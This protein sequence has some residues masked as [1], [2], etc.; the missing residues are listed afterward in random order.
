MIN[1]D[2]QDEREA[3]A[4]DEVATEHRPT[5][6]FALGIGLGGS[7]RHPRPN[8]L[9]ALENHPFALRQ[10]GLHNVKYALL[11]AKHH[12]PDGDRVVVVDHENEASG[13][14]LLNGGLRD[15][16]P[17]LL[18]ADLHHH[19]HVLTRQQNIIGIRKLAA[20]RLG[21]GGWG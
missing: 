12:P 21:A 5:P 11:V 18:F 9:H 16:Q 1:N 8:L 6:G 19:F 17:L 3:R 14:V 4:I 13:L 7:D 10:P 15:H 20:R 2:R